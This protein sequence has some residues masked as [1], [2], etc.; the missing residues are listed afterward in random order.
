MDGFILPCSDLYLLGVLNS[1][2]VWWFLQRIC[3]VLGNA[4]KGGRLRLKRQYVEKIPIPEAS[5]AEKDAIAK[6]VRKCLDARG[7]GC[8]KWEKEIEDRVLSL[9]GFASDGV[10]E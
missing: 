4:E 5:K 1:K 7:V 9:F 2:A 10:G 6:L 3:A 8:E